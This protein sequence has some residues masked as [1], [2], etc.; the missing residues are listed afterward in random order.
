MQTGPDEEFVL[1]A[2]GILGNL[3]VQDVN[4]QQLLNDYD[5][6]NYIKSKLHPGEKKLFVVY[7][8]GCFTLLLNQ[9]DKKKQITLRRQ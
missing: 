8:L 4:F 9:S 7:K 2:L 5:M 1:E 6:L 3:T